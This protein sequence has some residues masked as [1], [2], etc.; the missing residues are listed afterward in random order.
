M[1][2]L[3]A[4]TLLIAGCLCDPEPTTTDAPDFDD[5]RPVTLFDDANEQ[6]LPPVEVTTAKPVAIN[7]SQPMTPAASQQ[8]EPAA[9]T[10]AVVHVSDNCAPCHWLLTDLEMLHHQHGWT[11]AAGS[12]NI[13]ANW[14][15][16]HNTPGVEAFPRIDFF[17]DGSLQES[18]T[19]YVDSPRF[20][21]RRNLLAALVA[22]HN[23]LKEYGE[24]S[25]TPNVPQPPN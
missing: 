22:T 2:L 7:A 17:R 6:Y 24:T 23:A 19:G 14:I 13:P 4:L 12:E 10:G 16:E 15:L 9:F 8:Q 18:R 3:F 20:E 5:S 25:V 21:D 1:R 11:V